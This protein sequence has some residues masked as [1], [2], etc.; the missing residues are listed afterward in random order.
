MEH[1]NESQQ[2]R[3]QT[4]AAGQQKMSKTKDTQAVSRSTIVPREGYSDSMSGVA[5]ERAKVPRDM[6]KRAQ[7]KSNHV[8][9]ISAGDEL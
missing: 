6:S 1:F 8:R 5:Y 9:F 7:I 4:K 3:V 2:W